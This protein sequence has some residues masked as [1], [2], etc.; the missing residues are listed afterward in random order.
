MGIAC[1]YLGFRFGEPMMVAA[2]NTWAT[3]ASCT[4][5]SIVA[6][7]AAQNVGPFYTILALPCVRESLWMPE[8]F[9]CPIL[10]GLVAQ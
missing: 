1:N 2:L 10:F 4:R 7:F 9:R 6:T 8:R 3:L 5:T